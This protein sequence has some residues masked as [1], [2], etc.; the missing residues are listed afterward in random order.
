[1]LHE[2]IN[3]EQINNIGRVDDREPGNLDQHNS[4]MLVALNDFYAAFNQ[5]D[6]DKSISN[7]AP[8]N[9]VVMCNP[10]G[11]IRRGIASIQEG[12]Q[13]IMQGDTK[14]Y[15]EFYDYELLETDTISYV[16]GRERGYARR[17]TEQVEL[18][19]RTSRIFQQLGGLW[20]QVHHHG[21][22]TD[23]TALQQYQEFL[24]ATA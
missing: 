24:K 10:M 11:G 18:D 22:M 6:V 14:V 21:S 20:K 17:G 8:Q 16:A 13:T 9:N 12:Y 1:M 5:R 3:G 7:W 2:M 19:I 4:S 23:P 15:V